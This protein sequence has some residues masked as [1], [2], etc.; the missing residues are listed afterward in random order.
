[1]LAGIIYL[2]WRNVTF[3][4]KTNITA[5]AVTMVVN[6]LIWNDT[7][8]KLTPGPVLLGSSGGTAML[9]R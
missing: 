4:S 8:W 2:P 5:H 6:T 9:T 1:M 7:K 3:N